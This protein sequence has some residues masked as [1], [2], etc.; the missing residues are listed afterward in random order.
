MAIPAANHTPI[1]TRGTQANPVVNLTLRGLGLRDTAW[2]MPQPHGVPSGDWALE[3]M[4]A[5]L[6]GTESLVAE[7]LRFE[8][9]DGNA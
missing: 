3:R 4:A 1:D 9:V 5:L 6:E 8:R 2:T 7:G